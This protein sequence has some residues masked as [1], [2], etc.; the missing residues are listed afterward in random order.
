MF[1]EVHDAI[2]ITDDARRQSPGF[3]ASQLRNDI[4]LVNYTS[5]FYQGLE[6]QEISSILVEADIDLLRHEETEMC[7]L[8]AQT[9]NYH[10]SLELMYPELVRGSA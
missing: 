10:T 7:Q 5:D 2:T 3:V 1:Y 6:A 9:D 4:K 8:C